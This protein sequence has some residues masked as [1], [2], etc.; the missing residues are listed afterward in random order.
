MIRPQHPRPRSPP[1][2]VARPRIRSWI[3][4][5]LAAQV[6]RRRLNPAPETS[7][8]HSFPHDASIPDPRGPRS[9]RRT[10]T[11]T[12]LRTQTRSRCR[13]VSR[14]TTRSE[15]RARF[16]APLPAQRLERRSRE[17]FPRPVAR[18][19]I[20]RWTLDR[21]STQLPR[22]RLGPGTRDLHT[23]RLPARCSNPGNLIAARLPA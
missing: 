17:P 4:D 23:A 11:R 5:L 6:P 2:T 1:L 16:S 9:P 15:T 21:F 12:T 19:R 22:Q 3:H 7:T 20:R 13:P 8:P 10:V 14:T 18:P